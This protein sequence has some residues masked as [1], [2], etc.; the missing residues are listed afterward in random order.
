MNGLVGLNN[1]GNTCYMNA[2]LQCLRCVFALTRYIFNSRYDGSNKLVKSYFDFVKIIW[3]HKQITLSPSDLKKEFGKYKSEF[4]S[5]TQEDAQEFTNFLLD[6]LHENLKEEIE[7]IEIKSRKRIIRTRSIISDIFYGKYKSTVTCG[8]CSNNSDTYEDFMFLTLP[9]TQNLY[10]SFGQFNRHDHLD[11][12]NKYKCDKCNTL[13]NATK[14]MQIAKLPNT[15][16]IYLKR[17]NSVR[18]INDFMDI[19]FYF[20]SP[21]NIT[22]ELIAVINHYGNINGGHYTANIKFN[23]S[24]WYCMNDSQYQNIHPTKVIGCEAY[25]LYYQQT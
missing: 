3:T 25:V 21:D 10:T 8:N 23:N 14:K 6:S 22:F 15:L 5:F 11:G 12:E 24:I 19:P 1:L 17:F 13:S 7:E 18:K 2:S 9:V 16:I 20:T 4:D